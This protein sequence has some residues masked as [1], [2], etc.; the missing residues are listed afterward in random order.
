MIAH[1]TVQFLGL[2]HVSVAPTRSY[3]I[4]AK[5]FRTEAGLHQ[6]LAF[7]VNFDRKQQGLDPLPVLALPRSAIS[8]IPKEQ[9][10]F[11]HALCYL[12]F[13]V[14]VLP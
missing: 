4:P 2:H 7:A 6:A 3:W 8:S 9:Y 14:E 11:Y 10:G 13:V 12:C 1:C 5:G